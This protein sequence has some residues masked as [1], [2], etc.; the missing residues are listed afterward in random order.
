MTW[1]WAIT[2]AAAI[3]DIPRDSLE[4]AMQRRGLQPAN[5]RACEYQEFADMVR[6]E[7]TLIG[8]TRS[9]DAVMRAYGTLLAALPAAATH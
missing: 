2:R 9:T 5:M 3:L 4:G 8:K 7:I 6:S 1:E